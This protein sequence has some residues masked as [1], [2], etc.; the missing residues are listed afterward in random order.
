MEQHISDIH[1]SVMREMK[2]LR[3]AS[4]TNNR[5]ESDSM[6][7]IKMLQG[8]VSALKWRTESQRIQQRNS[9][10][11]PDLQGEPALLHN[12]YNSIL[13]HASLMRDNLSRLQAL[14]VAIILNR[15]MKSKCFDSCLIKYLVLEQSK[16]RTL[17]CDLP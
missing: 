10:M 3:K 16:K 9:T 8:E 11:Y 5:M 14:T 6:N 4:K 7:M 17:L 2:A 13:N 15:T 1:I 12:F